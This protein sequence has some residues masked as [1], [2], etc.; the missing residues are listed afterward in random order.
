[1]RGLSIQFAGRF[2]GP[3]LVRGGAEVGENA[4]YILLLL[5]Q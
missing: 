1:M 5:F 3:H 2:P 4:I